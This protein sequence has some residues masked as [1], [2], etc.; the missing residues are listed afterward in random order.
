MV[1]EGRTTQYEWGSRISI[2]TGLPT[3][4][5][6]HWHQTQ[7]RP[8]YSYAVDGRRAIV[9]NIYATPSQ[10]RALEMMEEYAVEYVV[11]GELERTQYPEVGLAKFDAMVGKELELAYENEQTKIYR[12]VPPRSGAP[13]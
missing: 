7:Q 8:G 12:V 11:V 1:L 4:L 10:D 2:Y 3:V 5:G 9:D 13:S 6:W